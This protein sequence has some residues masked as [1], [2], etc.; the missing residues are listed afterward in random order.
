MACG[1]SAYILADETREDYEETRL[2]WLEKYS[3]RRIITKRGWSI[4]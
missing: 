4:N 2:G 3:S 1:R